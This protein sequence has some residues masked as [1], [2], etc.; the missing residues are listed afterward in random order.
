MHDITVHIVLVL[1]I[2]GNMIGHLVDVNDAFLL[3][4]FKPDEKIYMK[5]P[6]GFEKFCPQGRLLFLKR[7]LY[8][9]RNAAKE[10]WRLLLQIINELGYQWNHANPCLYYKCDDKFGLSVWLSFIDDMLI[11]CAG[12]GMESIKKKFTETVDC[13]DIGEMKEYIGNKN[14]IDQHNKTLKITQPVLVQSLNDEFNFA[15]PNSKPAF[16]E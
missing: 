11:V 10:F 4:E 12:D 15:E 6:W 5:I 8:S 13:N 1:M 14:N 7:T 16:N 2:M 9:V 3:G